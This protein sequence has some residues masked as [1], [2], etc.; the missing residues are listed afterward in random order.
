MSVNP[1]P[2]Y[3]HPD[4]SAPLDVLDGPVQTWNEDLPAYSTVTVATVLTTGYKYVGLY[5]AN[6]AVAQTASFYWSI[7]GRYGFTPQFDD[8]VSVPPGAF[9]PFFLLTA[10]AQLLTLAITD[11]SGA[12]N[13]AKG[14][15]W[16]T[17]RLPFN[18]NVDN[19]TIWDS[20]GSHPLAPGWN[21]EPF[22]V[23]S[24]GLAVISVGADVGYDVEIDY[25]D[26]NG[27]WDYIWSD[28]G[29]TANVPTSSIVALPSGYCRIGIN[30]TGG[31]NQSATAA[32][33]SS[34]NMSS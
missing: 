17:N 3:G 26:L 20:G 28:S 25:L 21:Y 19:F 10:K 1:S 9:S 5:M 2:G 12:D 30:N 33:V 22:N 24:G 16:P 27:Q 23:V 34:V 13:T 32:V 14:S 11:T 8:Y 4:F 31:G 7:T 15:C 6:G 18:P 29:L